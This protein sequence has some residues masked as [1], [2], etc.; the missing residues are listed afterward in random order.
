M[1]RILVSSLYS[2]NYGDA[3]IDRVAPNGDAN[4]LQRSVKLWLKGQVQ[5]IEGG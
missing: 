4:I 2:P 5:D 3:F 1:S